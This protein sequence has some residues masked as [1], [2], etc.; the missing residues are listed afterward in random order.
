[1]IEKAR[2]NLIVAYSIRGRGK[3]RVKIAEYKLKGGGIKTEG[4]RDTRG[5]QEL[6]E[7]LQ[8]KNSG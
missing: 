1:M 4:G 6:K 7:G 2:D 8:R 5:F 3:G